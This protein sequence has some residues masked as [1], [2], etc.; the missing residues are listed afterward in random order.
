MRGAGTWR[1][2]RLAPG[3][4]W[5]DPTG[6]VWPPAILNVT[7][8]PG[9]IATWPAA[10]GWRRCPCDL[11][12]AVVLAESGAEER[13]ARW[14]RRDATASPDGVTCL[15]GRG[16]RVNGIYGPASGGVCVCVAFQ[17]E[18]GLTPDGAV[19]RAPGRW[20]GL[21]ACPDEG[22]RSAPARA[23]YCSATHHH[24]AERRSARDI[25][26]RPRAYPGRS[27]AP[28]R[29]SCWPL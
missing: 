18:K 6:R 29:P 8:P 4:V 2:R 28:S 10:T 27:T 3:G 25:P 16:S 24:A 11:L 26:E 21:R 20:P 22:Q 1:R 5:P 15:E 7:V 17:R 13:E 12:A 23:W 9:L 14:F 19:G